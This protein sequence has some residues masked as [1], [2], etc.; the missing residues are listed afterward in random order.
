MVCPRK[1]EW[2]QMS[3]EERYDA[4]LAGKAPYSIWSKLWRN[5]FM[6]WLAIHPRIIMPVI[7]TLGIGI[8]IVLKLCNVINSWWIALI[9]VWIAIIAIVIFALMGIFIASI[10][11]EQFDSAWL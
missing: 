7:C 5:R 10:I 3:P 6:N 2:E 1:N 8:P 9:P 4:E 11:L